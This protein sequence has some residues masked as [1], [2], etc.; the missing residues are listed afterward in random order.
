MTFKIRF[1]L[2]SFVC[3]WFTFL[4]A[5]I[6]TNQLQN[7]PSLGHYAFDIASNPN[8][9]PPKVRKPPY[10]PTN[11]PCAGN[12]KYSDSLLLKLTLRSNSNEWHCFEF[13]TGSLN[14]LLLHPKDSLCG[15][16]N[17]GYVPL[18]PFNH[19]IDNQ[20]YPL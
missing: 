1:R 2:F 17:K 18:N 15:D 6:S 12:F 7:D 14:P 19:Q 11:V 8:M 20:P 5:S 3:F 4:F 16:L 13:V 9:L 10:I